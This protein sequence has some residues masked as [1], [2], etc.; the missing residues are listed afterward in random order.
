VIYGL[1]RP[2]YAVGHTLKHLWLKQLGDINKEQ[3]L[4][5]Q[6]FQWTNKGLGSSVL[7]VEWSK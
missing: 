5:N 4:P 6:K 2:L 7:G 3:N 1:S